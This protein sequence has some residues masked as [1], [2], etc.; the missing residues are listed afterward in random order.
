[1]DGG[2]G[3]IEQPQS[4][5][6]KRCFFGTAGTSSASP[7]PLENKGK[8]ILPIDIQYVTANLKASTVTSEV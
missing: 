4:A 5:S 3:L 2:R 7:D 8:K 1:V 6:G